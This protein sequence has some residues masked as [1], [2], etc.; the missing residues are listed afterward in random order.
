MTMPNN[1]SQRRI[2]ELITAE[3]GD[4]N[5]P[6]PE[7]FLA[8]DEMTPLERAVLERLEAQGLRNLAMNAIMTEREKDKKAKELGQRVANIEGFI[9]AAVAAAQSNRTQQPAQP[10]RKR[11]ENTNRPR[12]L[13]EW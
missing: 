4:I 10:P 8:Y 13:G 3:Y 11:V 9:S 7:N 12:Q 2:M 5:A 6:A 1:L